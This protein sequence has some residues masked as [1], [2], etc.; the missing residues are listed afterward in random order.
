LH[1]RIDEGVGVQWLSWTRYDP[2][3]K[4]IVFLE[5]LVW[6]EIVIENEEDPHGMLLLLEWS[7]AV[8]GKAER[9]IMMVQE[10]IMG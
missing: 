7:K 6:R 1:E 10:V 2:N 4:D 8:S 5:A 3:T 9:D